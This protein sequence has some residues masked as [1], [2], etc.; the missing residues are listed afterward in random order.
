VVLQAGEDPAITRDGLARTLRAIRSE[1]GLAITLSLGERPV[2]DYAAWREAGADRVLLRFESSNPAL[3]SEI[4]PPRADAPCDRVGLLRELRE[5]GYE[6]GSGMLVGLPGSTYDDLAR[7]L[8]LCGALDLDMIGLGPF[9]PN[10]ET[11]LGADGV[12][13]SEVPATAGMTLVVLALARLACPEANIPATTALAT[14]DPETGYERGL[15]CGA[16]VIMPNVGVEEYRNDYAIYPGKLRAH[17]A[18][19]GIHRTCE[20]LRQRLVRMGRPPAAGP[21]ASR[22]YQRRRAAPCPPAPS[23]RE[24]PSCPRFPR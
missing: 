19:E 8:E 10:P 9:V 7:D 12:E 20:R 14:L 23:D 3:F 17:Q 18:G 15:R 1:T 11:P 24:A 4:H 2:E 21:G 5:L 16:N 22:V 13:P 6:I